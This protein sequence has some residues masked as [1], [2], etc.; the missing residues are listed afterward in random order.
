MLAV[1]AVM[2]GMDNLLFELGRT[3]QKMEMRPDVHRPAAATRSEG[4][5]NTGRS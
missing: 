1:S 2:A 3:V 4:R 5:G